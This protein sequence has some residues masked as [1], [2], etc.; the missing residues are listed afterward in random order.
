MSKPLVSVILPVH[1]G[2]PFLPAAVTSILGQEFGDFELLVVDDHSSDGAVDL[3]QQA[4][5]RLKILPSRG[6][7]VVNAFDTGLAAAKG[8]YI[9]RMD[10][11]DIALPG[12]LGSQ[13]DLMEQHADI[14]IAGGRV[15]FFSSD[16]VADGNLHYQDWLNSVCSPEEIHT[17]LFIES[18]IPNPTAMFRAPAIHKLGGYRNCTWPEDYDLFLRA[19]QAGMKMAKPDEVLLE[20]RDHP[21]RLTRTDELYSR[22]RFQAAKAHY[23][24]HGRLPRGE[25]LIW[26]AGPTG[27]LMHDLLLAEGVETGGFI[28]VHPRRIGGTKRGKPVYGVDRAGVRD[29]SFIVAAVGSRGAR[30]KIRDFMQN[31]GRREGEEFL[32]VA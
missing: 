28:E 1:D 21:G 17:Q 22:E 32:F 11:D 7:G 8:Q 31:N 25:I 10:A 29:G 3:L 27:R 16:G 12:R 4:D 9:A 18:P 26:G 23:L 6:R 2:G 19:D 30:S 20:W 24:A 14:D 13:L 15:R 5:Q